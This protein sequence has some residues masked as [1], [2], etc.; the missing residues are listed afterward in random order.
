MHTWANEF[1]SLLLGFSIEGT[2]NLQIPIMGLFPMRH[3]LSI[4][5][6]STCDCFSSSTIKSLSTNAQE[7]SR[8]QTD[9]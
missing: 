4:A 8:E 7:A 5:K 1:C 6:F 3:T 2:Q 9:G